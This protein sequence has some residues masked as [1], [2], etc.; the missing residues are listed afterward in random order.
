MVEFFTS[1]LCAIES[2]IKCARLVF[3]LMTCCFAH[4]KMKFELVLKGAFAGGGGEGGMVCNGLVQRKMLRL[5]I[6]LINHL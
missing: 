2:V 1:K 5:E 3:C 6:F 4:K